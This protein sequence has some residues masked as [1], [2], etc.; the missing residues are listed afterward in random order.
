VTSAF[1]D[2]PI[3]GGEFTQSRASFEAAIRNDSTAPSYVLISVVDDRTESQR[4]ICTTANLLL[5][6]I[7]HEYALGYD[8]KGQSETERIALSSNTH[9]FRFAKQ[10]ALNNIPSS[11]SASDIARM[12]ATLAPLSIEQLRAGLASH[13]NLHS[14]YQVEPLALHKANRDALA[15]VLIERGLSPGIGDITDQLWLAP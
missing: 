11:Y 1:A 10:D 12:S 15:C 3:S 9:V 14:L 5:G 2:R 4:S 13:G 7:H 6:A 8:K